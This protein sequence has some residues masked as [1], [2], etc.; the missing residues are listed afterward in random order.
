MLLHLSTFEVGLLGDPSQTLAA[1]QSVTT[2]VAM[3]M[4]LVTPKA[5]AKVELLLNKPASEL[6][7]IRSN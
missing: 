7:E 2:F 6:I 5:A 3:V 4:Y 1:Q